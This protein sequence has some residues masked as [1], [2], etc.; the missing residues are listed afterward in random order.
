M[1]ES[2]LL[3][4]RLSAKGFLFIALIIFFPARSFAQ[5]IEGPRVLGL[6][7]A[8]AA[9]ADDTS[10]VR[11]NPA[12]MALKKTYTV[13]LNSQRIHGG[14]EAL[15]VTIIDSHTSELATGVSYTRE[16]EKEI[17][18]DFGILAIAQPY[19]D[20]FIGMSAKYF[21]DKGTDEKDYSYDVGA[22]MHASDRLSIGLVGKNLASTRFAFVRKTYTAGLA[23]LLVP[24]LTASFDAT[25]DPD[26]TG[27]DKIYAA[28]L[29]YAFN[30][31]LR[32]RSGYTDDTITD[33]TYYSVGF[34]YAAPEISLNYGYRR[35]KDD[36]SNNIQAFSLLLFF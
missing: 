23:Y 20:F 4:K 22:I 10:A 30:Q 16:K 34:T 21:S 27:D 3:R 8:F 9:I 11:I 18:R 25:K 33:I 17:R 2:C 13:E 19:G 1:E 28:G 31:E 35:D 6:G 24:A 7:G 5:E 36:G 29:E 32:I 12:G 15:N 14:P 26:L